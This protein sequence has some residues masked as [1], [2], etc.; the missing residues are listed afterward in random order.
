MRTS[1]SCGGT[2]RAPRAS[3]PVCV[4]SRLFL[5]GTLFLSDM[6]GLQCGFAQFGGRCGPGVLQVLAQAAGGCLDVVGVGFQDL[7]HRAYG[8]LLGGNAVAGAA[9][10][11]P[12]GAR[13]RRFPR[14]R[15]ARPGPGRRGLRRGPAGLRVLRGRRSVSGR[16]RRSMQPGFAGRGQV[17]EQAAD[18]GQH[19]PGHAGGVCCP[20][21]WRRAQPCAAGLQPPLP[22]QARIGRAGPGDGRQHVGCRFQAQFGARPAG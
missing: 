11:D 19:G 18:L 1:G 13:R 3:H 17:F 9:V 22:R 6:R 14:L 5:A 15:S 7:G 8:D 20:G 10:T 21:R 16:L 2:R 4:P 12:P